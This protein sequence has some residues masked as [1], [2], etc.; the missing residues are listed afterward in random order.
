MGIGAQLYLLFDFSSF[1][2]VT[3]GKVVAILFIFPFLFGISPGFYFLTCEGRCWHLLCLA[4]TEVV[5]MGGAGTW[6]S[7]DGFI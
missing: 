3:W 4:V 2:P 7:E 5:V 1:C 6:K